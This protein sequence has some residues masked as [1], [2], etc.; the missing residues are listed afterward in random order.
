L[1]QKCLDIQDKRL[2]EKVH[3]LTAHGFVAELDPSICDGMKSIKNIIINNTTWVNG[4]KN[5]TT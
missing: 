2:H 1:L 4:A 3:L 5:R